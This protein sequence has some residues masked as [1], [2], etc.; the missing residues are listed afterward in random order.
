MTTEKNQRTGLF[1]RVMTR[2]EDVKEEVNA[3]HEEH[4]RDDHVDSVKDPDG[5][6]IMDT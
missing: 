3:G 2:E 4:H 1:G 5:R 6:V